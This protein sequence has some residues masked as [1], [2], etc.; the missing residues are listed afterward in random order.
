[1]AIVVGSGAGGAT[2]AKE[3]A[4]LGHRVLLI[5]KGPEIAEKDAHLYYANVD[6]GVKLMRTCCLGGTTMVSAGNA[7]RCLEAELR[8]LGIDLSAEFAEAEQEL[9]V[10]ELPEDLIGEGTRQLMD[11][12][13]RLGFPV[14][15]M[16]KFIDPLECCRDGRCSL[17]CPTSARW[18]AVRFIR[19]ARQKG[20]EVITGRTVTGVLT[21]H[22]Q[23]TGVRCGSQVYSDDLV[24]IAAG[25]LETPRLIGSIGI[26]T[27]PLFCDTFA[28]IGGICPGIGFNLDV[29]MGAYLTHGRSL[30][31][32][33]Y[34]R[35]LVAMLQRSGRSVGE[36]DILAMMVKIAD[37]D[38]G[39]VGE[40][41]EK[42]VTGNDARLLSSGASVAGAILEEAGTDPVTFATAPLRGSHPGGTA[43]IGVS[44]DTTL[45]TRIAGLYVADASV[46]P[47]APGA[48]PILA[49][50]ALAKYAAKRM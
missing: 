39:F 6:T 38:E 1:M 23:V 24:V 31:M 25:A 12:A 36:G 22:G 18:N 29:P 47:S 3:L 2:V 28:T 20:A 19:T 5:E 21:S 4:V 43:R 8:A 49:I 32:P 10:Q 44:V 34:S 42:G 13:L 9:G 14:R 11:A 48:P 16:P 37:E 45:M 33:H 50:I 26:P 46:L 30:I 27:S 35:Q 7:L 15:K 17:G 40:T 41:V